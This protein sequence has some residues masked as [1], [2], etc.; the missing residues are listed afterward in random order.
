MNAAMIGWAET[1]GLPGK[2]ASSVNGM[3]Q[4][5]GLR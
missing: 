4:R 3:G 2:L 5:I 1:S